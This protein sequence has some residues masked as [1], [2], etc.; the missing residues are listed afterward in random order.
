MW[1]TNGQKRLNLAYHMILTID[2]FRFSGMVL[3]GV[4]RKSKVIKVAI[5]YRWSKI[6]VT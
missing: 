3:D 6:F 5:I 1:E 2:D 4:S